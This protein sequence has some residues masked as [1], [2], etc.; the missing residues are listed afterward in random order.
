[1]ISA[2]RFPAA[3][4]GDLPREQVFDLFGID[5]AKHGR[6]ALIGAAMRAELARDFA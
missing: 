2:G 3:S 6:M 4:A 5:H 1:V